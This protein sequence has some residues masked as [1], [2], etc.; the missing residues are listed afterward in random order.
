[1]HARVTGLA[2]GKT[3]YYRF[4]A[5]NKNGT[6]LGPEEHFKTEPVPPIVIS[7]SVSAVA[8]GYAILEAQINPSGEATYYAEYGTGACGANT[9]GAKTSGEGF[10][11]G[12]T[13]EEGSL[14][15]PI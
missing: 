2:P 8:E 6:E 9:C 1:M 13:Q 10:V 15:P 4:S 7:E 12:D 11:L 14:R 3:Y 5:T